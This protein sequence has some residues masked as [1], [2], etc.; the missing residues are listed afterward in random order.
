MK[1]DLVDF[2]KFIS[3]H[4]LKEIKN[5]VYFNFGNSPTEDG[6]FSYEIFGNVG[7]DE[8]KQTYA[9]IDLKRKFLHPLMYIML[10]SMDRKIIN[11]VN[12]SK[13]FIIEN[14][15]LKEDNEKGETGLD[16]LYKNF[17]KIKFK[18][19]GSIKRNEKNVLLEKTPL[20]QI[21]ID[22]FLVIP[23]YYR[24]F[25]PNTK[26]GEKINDVD[27][28]NDSY[29]KIIRLSQTLSNDSGSFD[30]ISNNTMYNI[31]MELNK[32]FTQLTQSLAKKNGLIHQSL[33]GKSVDYATRSVISTS[34]VA[35]NNW[36]DNEVRIGYT[37]VPLSQLCVLFFPFFIKF[38]SDFIDEHI[39]EFSNPRDSKGNKVHIENVKEQFNEKAIKKLL[40]LYIKSVE[41]RF[42]PI[43]VKDKD[44]KEYNVY[45]YENELKRP[46]AM[47]DLLF[48][49][50]LEVCK[51]KH[52]YVT[53]Y[54]IEHY[55]NIYPSKIKIL[56]TLKTM[57]VQLGSNY[58]KDYPLVIKD[59]PYLQKYFIDT[60]H[61]SQV[62]TL[63]LNADFDGDTISLRAV[64]SKEANEEAERLINKKTFYLN[65][66]GEPMRVITME[67][68]Q[69]LYTLTC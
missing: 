39:E 27:I 26:D 62:Y 12:G 44:D 9:Y 16:F 69:A 20:D 18:Y 65:Q 36:E 46:F 25:N 45:V 47:V 54:P 31:Q 21:F 50:A 1:I 14:G 24:D 57:E 22:K 48:I 68:I 35:N 41:K 2:N 8:R 51:D 52:V 37:A 49:T 40:G 67:A 56:S 43:L 23:P 61:I 3:D 42:D 66:N 30:F 29:S 64:Y 28:I 4:Q 10:T 32:I 34:R 38:I 63:A 6:L 60:V 58:I 7:S 13:Y 15:E 5:S 55:Q 53:R 59:Y 33:I 17:S 19:T 11:I